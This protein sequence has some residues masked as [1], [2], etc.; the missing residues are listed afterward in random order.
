MCWA[1]VT[2][3]SYSSFNALFFH[4]NSEGAESINPR[5]K[6][7]ILPNILYAI[8]NTPLVRINNISK[9][10]GLQCELRKAT[11]FLW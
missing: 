1:S 11:C 5:V 3:E 8:G 4:D 9:A 2:S 6:P 10:A 7:A